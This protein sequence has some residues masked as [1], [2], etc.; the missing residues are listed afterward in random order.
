MSGG[1]PSQAGLATGTTAGL[2]ASL[3]TAT[4]RVTTTS[5]ALIATPSPVVVR[6]GGGKRGAAPR[7]PVAQP[8]TC[9]PVPH[10]PGRAPARRQARQGRFERARPPPGQRA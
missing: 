2:P 8:P 9:R 10:T 1:C 4:T 3:T 7:R 6:I 5:F